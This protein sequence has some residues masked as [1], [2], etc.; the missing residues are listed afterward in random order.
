MLQLRLSEACDTSSITED[1][2]LTGTS[3][4]RAL[5]RW[6]RDQANDMPKTD[7]QVRN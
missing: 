3:R 5:Y 6:R 1:R 2:L 4:I 7:L